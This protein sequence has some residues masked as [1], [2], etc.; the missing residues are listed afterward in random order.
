MV[1][2]EL[3]MCANIGHTTTVGWSAHVPVDRALCR[4]SGNCWLHSGVSLDSY[5]KH[6]SPCCG[7]RARAGGSAP[8]SP[9]PLVMAA[10]WIFGG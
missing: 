5:A 9:S 2:I 10:S 1:V 6:P 8:R 4:P 3:C 7:N